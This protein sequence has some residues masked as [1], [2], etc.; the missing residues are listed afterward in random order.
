MAAAPLLSVII[1]VLNEAPLVQASAA[2][3]KALEA[4][5]AEVLLVDGG[6]GDGTTALLEQAGLAVLH[7]ERG[8]GRQLRLGAERARGERL[9]FLHADT[10]LPEGALAL[11]QSSL[12]E[13]RCWGRF[14]VRIAGRSPLLPVVAWAMNW[15]SRLTG[16]ATGDQ[17]LFMTR[18]AY[19]QVGGFADQPLMEDIDLSARLRRLGWPACVRPPVCTS[20]RRWESR[21]VGRTIVLMWA[22]R[23]AYAL[24]A[25]PRLLVRFYG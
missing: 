14:D 17:A 25:P 23:L 13:G 24:G 21:G 20:G 8:R 22:L 1:P 4:E 7:S 18:Q 6:S 19:A 9:L 16:I 10:Q 12:D 5:G 11:V 15:R 2:T 3:W